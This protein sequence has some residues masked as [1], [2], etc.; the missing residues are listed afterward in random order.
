MMFSEDLAHPVPLYYLFRGYINQPIH[1]ELS[2]S[3]EQCLVLNL[4]HPK[5]SV[6]L[7]LYDICL[8]F[9]SESSSPL[10]HCIMSHVN[11]LTNK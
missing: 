7:I 6:T 10:S 5:S 1:F 4:K 8:S 9:F 11:D 3:V 2:P